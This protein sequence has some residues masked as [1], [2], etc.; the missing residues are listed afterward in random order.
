MP[1]AD[2]CLVRTRVVTEGE[3][4]PLLIHAKPGAKPDRQIIS[5]FPGARP[6]VRS[7]IRKHA[8]GWLALSLRSPGRP[9]FFT[10]SRNAGG[11]LVVQGALAC[12]AA[13]Q[14]VRQE[15]VATRAAGLG[16]VRERRER[17][18]WV[19]VDCLYCI[20]R[21]TPLADYVSGAVL[22]VDGGTIRSVH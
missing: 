14:S 10:D 18:R 11:C 3:R 2:R 16:L 4:P 7:R 19:R 22:R 17:A 8:A 1:D 5:S 20:C 12:G 15:L 21:A 6:Q 13:A 9:H